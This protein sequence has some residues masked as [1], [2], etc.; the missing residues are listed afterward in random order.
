MTQITQEWAH[1]VIRASRCPR[2]VGPGWNHFVSVFVDALLWEPCDWRWGCCTVPAVRLSGW[3]WP[4]CR[5]SKSHLRS[6]HLVQEMDPL[7]FERD[8][9]VLQLCIR[10]MFVQMGLK[11]RGRTRRYTNTKSAWAANKVK[12]R[13]VLEPFE[14]SHIFL[15]DILFP[16]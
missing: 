8:C 13:K 7:S 11:P 1:L 3:F 2:G 12:S 10:C 4:F 9:G 16:L 14:W 6:H 5:L 15:S